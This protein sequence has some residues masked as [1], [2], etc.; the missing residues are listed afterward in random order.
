[1]V[2]LSSWTWVLSFCSLYSPFWGALVY[3][4]L[5][6]FHQIEGELHIVGFIMACIG[7]LDSHLALYNG[8]DALDPLESH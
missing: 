2:H 4:W 7:I 8:G 6:R 3:L 1:M 5:A